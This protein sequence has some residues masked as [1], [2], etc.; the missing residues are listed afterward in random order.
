MSNSNNPYSGFSKRT[1]TDYDEGE[2]RGPGEEQ[3]RGQRERQGQEGFKGHSAAFQGYDPESGKLGRRRSLI[4][5]D[6]SRACSGSQNYHYR[7]SPLGVGTGMTPGLPNPTG[8]A[9]PHSGPATSTGGYRGYYDHQTFPLTYHDDI[10]LQSLPPMKESDF[11]GKGTSFTQQ[12]LDTGENNGINMGSSHNAL[13]FVINDDDDMESAISVDTIQPEEPETVPLTGR[14]YT[15][16]TSSR[17]RNLEKDPRNFPFWKEYCYLVTFWAPSPLLQLFGLKT[18]QRQYAWRE[19]MGLISIILVLGG[20]IAFLTFGFT[21]SVCTGMTTRLHADTISTGY[22]VIN[23]RVYNLDSSSHPAAPGIQAGTNVLYSPVNAGGKDASLLF[24]NVNGNCRGLIVPRENCTIPN[25]DGNLA[26]YMP[27]KAIDIDG[28]THPNFTFDYY[29]GYACHTSAKARK[30]FYSLKVEGNVYYSWDDIANTTRNLVVFNGNVLDMDLLDWLEKDDLEYPALFDSI[31]NNPSMKGYDISRL[32]SD[33]S[34]RQVANCLVEIV[35]IGVIDTSTVGCIAASIVLYVSLVFVLALVIVQF[36]VAC[37]FKWFV[38]PNQGVNKSTLKETNSKAE[39]IEEWTDNP[40]SQSMMSKRRADYHNRDESSNS[41]AAARANAHS[42]NNTKRKALR[43]SWGG[44]ILDFIDRKDQKET[45]PISDYVPKYLTMTTEAY[46]VS[47]KSRGHVR[48]LSTQSLATLETY[49][50]DPFKNP[51]PEG[52][53]DMDIQTL[54]S[55]LVHPNVMSQPPVGWEPFGYPLIYTMC[56]VTCYSEDKGGIRTTIDSIATTNYPNSHKLIIIICDGLITGAGNQKST[57]DICLDMMSDLVL[58]KDQV[59]PHSYVSVAEGS[60]RHNMAKVYAG[61]YQYDDTTVPPENQPQIPIMLIVKCGTPAEISSAKPGN[62]GKRD[63]QIILMSFLQSIT[64]NER[65]S[66]LEFEMLKSIW[67]VTGLMATFYEALLMVDADTLV[68]PDSLTHL[69]AELVRDPE[70]MGL[71]GETKI[72]N[73]TQSW[74]TAIQVF[75]YYI[76]HHQAKAFESVFGSVTCLPGCFCMYRIKAPKD[77]NVWVP[78]LANADIVAKYSDNVLDS[79]HKKNLLLLGEDRFLSSLMLRTF[80]RRKQIFVP[81]AVCKTIV[82]DKFNILL[83][84]RRRWINST[85]HNLMEL[86]MVKDLCGTFC[87]SM[88]FVIIVQLIG[89]LVLPASITFTLYIIIVA[90]FS[91]DKP[92][93]SLILM[94]IVFGLPAIL[95]VVTVSNPM[96]VIWM[97]IYLASLPIWNFILPSYAYWK[98]DDFSWGD[99]RKTQATD[100]TNPETK[101]EFDGSQIVHMT[102]R[103][104]ERKRIRLERS[105]IPVAYNPGYHDGNNR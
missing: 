86:A 49:V 48:G 17:L 59:Q 27:C 4:R 42:A 79:L 68:F 45:Q 38:A 12:V 25:K 30:A 24:Q 15:T 9:G 2:T 3:N 31:K 70:V 58:P 61:F 64:F 57:P 5:R 105:G 10:P 23:G 51:V 44:D 28:S 84:Q 99:T 63:S 72:A 39:K 33:A 92:I 81:K 83:S 43:L 40:S 54:D 14:N 7:S 18:A 21:R 89:T 77:I 6:R 100:R 87:F 88:Q 13:P 67:Q 78:I 80:P 66:E 53:S 65:M 34:Q 20:I 91:P 90:I 85:V 37:Y 102:W 47:Q 73:K 96:Y 74:V 62:R 52:S 97:F 35:K 71:C 19:K 75:E 11:E 104:Y 69:V 82:P 56:L 95:I 50:Q 36:V 93:M 60:K 94:G 32:L 41:L 8:Y 16:M 98:F 46:L 103:E 22:L 26:W 1:S 76:S 29:D 101:G 55:S